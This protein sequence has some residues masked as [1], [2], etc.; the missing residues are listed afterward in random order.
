MPY[1]SLQR[2]KDHHYA[3]DPSYADIG[4]SAGIE[5]SVMRWLNRSDPFVAVAYS[6]C[7]FWLLH[8]KDHQGEPKGKNDSFRRN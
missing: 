6:Q 4:F 8:R 7:S 2:S 1:Y 5:A 3:A